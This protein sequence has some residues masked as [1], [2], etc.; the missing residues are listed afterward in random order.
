MKPQEAFLSAFALHT[1]GVAVITANSPSGN[2]VGFTATSL[3]SFSAFP[4][5]ASFNMSQHASSYRALAIDS[6]VLLHFLAE[7][8]VALSKQMSGP[9]D[10]RFAG[11][12][13]VA[14][15]DGL[16]RLNG[17][18]AMLSARVVSVAEVGENATVIV[19]IDGGETNPERKPLV[20][21]ERGYHS[22]GDSL[23]D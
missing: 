11:E 10:E 5:R 17:V 19:E 16:P 6:K 13:W 21:V 20:Y 18:R 7:D 22:I 14:D 23:G 8:Q 12:H 2:P 3:T 9:V 15:G 4:P 1:A